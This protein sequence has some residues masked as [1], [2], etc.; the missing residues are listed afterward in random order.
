MSNN[1][2]VIISGA[3]MDL[4][5]A[6][7]GLIHEKSEKLFKHNHDIIRLNV[8]V[9]PDIKKNAKETFTAKAHLEV[10]GPDIHASETTEDL[11]KSIDGMMQKLDRQLREKHEAEVA[12]RKHPH[13]VEIPSEIPKAY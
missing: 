11:Y 12:K 4:T 1:D 5:E 9:G 8:H 10:N 7:K 3:N 6:I 13:A 2:K